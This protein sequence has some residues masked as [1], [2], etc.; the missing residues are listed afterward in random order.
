[1][2]LFWPFFSHQHKHV[3]CSQSIYLPSHLLLCHHHH[4]DE[5]LAATAS[6]W[7]SDKWRRLSGRTICLKKES[8][9]Q[10]VLARHRISRLNEPFKAQM[11]LSHRRWMSHHSASRFRFSPIIQTTI[12]DA[13]RQNGTHTTQ[14]R[15]SNNRVLIVQLL[16]GRV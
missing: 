11:Y 8:Q 1:M 3:V 10:A 7:Y 2:R 13:T 15:A 14:Y 12:C 9:N 6:A 5:K 4:F 16:P